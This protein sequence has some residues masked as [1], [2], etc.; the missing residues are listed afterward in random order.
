MFIVEIFRVT[1][2]SLGA[3]FVCSFFMFQIFL[4]FV[5]KTQLSTFLKHYTILRLKYRMYRMN[6]C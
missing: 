1:F 2:L 3:S 4:R 6:N 5:I